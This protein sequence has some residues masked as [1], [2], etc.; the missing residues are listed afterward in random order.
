MFRRGR[1]GDRVAPGEWSRLARQVACASF[2]LCCLGVVALDLTGAGN[3]RM[4]SFKT[5]GAREDGQTA[6]ELRGGRCVVRGGIADMDDLVLAFLQENGG[7]VEI[8]SP[9]CAFSE[10]TRVGRSEAP[11]HVRSR[12]L[13]LDGVG[14]DVFVDSRKL[15]VRSNVHMIIM[16]TGSRAEKLYPFSTS[17]RRSEAVPTPAKQE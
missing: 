6:W 17:P 12:A 15:H 11:I 8:T 13:T 1:K 4:S 14:Y 7:R 5:R 9:K 16:K 10:G 3:M 2:C